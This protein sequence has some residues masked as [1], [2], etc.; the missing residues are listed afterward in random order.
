MTNN[1]IIFILPT[2]HEIV[3]RKDVKRILT[4][5]GGG[6]RGTFPASFLAAIEEDLDEPIGHYF[7]LIAGT[8]TGGIIAIALALGIPAKRILK[9]Y[10][11]HG[12]NIFSQDQK[13]IQRWLTKQYLN[14]KWFGWGPKYSTEPLKLALSDVFQNKKIGDA[15]TRLMIPSWHSQSK[16]VYVYK[17]AHHERLTTDYKDSALDAALATAAAP[18]YFREHITA[19]DVGLVDG[20][21]WANNPAGFAVAEAIGVL[22][23]KPEEISLLS[24]SCLEDIFDM[25]PAYSARS[26]V[27]KTA[28]FFMAGQSHG[29]MGLAHI[30]TGDPHERK[31]IWRICQ[32]APDGA[33]SMDNTDKIRHL[34]DRGFV[35]AREQKPILKSHFFTK[36]AD[37]FTPIYSL[38]DLPK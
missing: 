36:T 19:N 5:D 30:L 17:T 31:A 38:Q 16:K 9:L 8:S 18:T 26:I 33:F 4:I 12:P 35:E 20:G 22:K 27:H 1:K 25:K 34:K 11:E 29:S 37:K 15:R 28:D 24:I 2:A 14:L 13:G 7:D 21:L 10:E 3:W 32:P 23:W 6:I